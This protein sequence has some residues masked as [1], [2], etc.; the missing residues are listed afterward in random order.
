MKKEK[1]L[2]LSISE[3]GFTSDARNLWVEQVLQH[4]DPNFQRDF[5]EKGLRTLKEW[6]QKLTVRELME[7]IDAER[8]K[9]G[10]SRYKRRLGSA[11]KQLIDKLV[12]CGLTQLDWVELP[13]STVTTDMLQRLGKENVCSLPARVLCT[14]SQRALH[15]LGCEVLQNYSP[16]PPDFT[17]QNLLNVPLGGLGKGVWSTSGIWKQFNTSVV[18]TRQKLRE[19]GFRYEDGPF[20]QDG[21]KRQLV[22]SLMEEDGFSRKMALRVAEIAEKRRWVARFVE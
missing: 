11:E 15:F 22:E 2:A 1:V 21:T 8:A 4:G 20:L 6:A 13:S 3:L 18:K 16:S 7:A 17:I 12:E 19:I 10:E 5:S 14:L 9:R